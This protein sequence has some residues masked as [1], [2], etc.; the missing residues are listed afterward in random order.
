MLAMAPAPGGGQPSQGSPIF[1]IIGLL[2]W[3][4]IIIGLWL[5][6]CRKRPLVMQATGIV[7]TIGGLFLGLWARAHSPN[8]GFGEMVTKLDTFILKE[9]FYYAFIITAACLVLGG[10]ILFIKGFGARI[11]KLA[12][13]LTGE[14]GSS[15][16]EI[17]K[18][19][20]LLD[21]GAIDAAEF[22][23]IKKAALDR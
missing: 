19:K 14:K 2:I 10:V 15:L 16:D 7:F 18:A 21:S 4:L 13:I 23:K 20:E 6:F 5:R 1:Q 22:E 3:L 17:K 11:P 9:P 8:M 12:N